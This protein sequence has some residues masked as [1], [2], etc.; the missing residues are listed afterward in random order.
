MIGST[1]TIETTFVE[2]QCGQCGGVYALQKAYHDKKR[3][4][5]GFW[6]CPYCKAGWGYAKEGSENWRLQRDKEK[7]ESSL[8]AKDDLLAVERARHDQTRASLRAHIGVATKLR[9]KVERT[10]K[11]VCPHCN[12][13]FANL[14]RHVE[15]KHG[16]RNHHE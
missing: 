13:Y 16:E 3:Q 6:T 9:K 15:T 8:R 14:H 4:E 11:G 1:V 12:R 10:E 2:V 5:G 7:L